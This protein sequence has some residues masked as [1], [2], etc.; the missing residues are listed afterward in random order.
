MASFFDAFGTDIIAGGSTLA[1]V[2]GALKLLY[3]ALKDERQRVASLGDKYA[4]ELER[5]RKSFEDERLEWVKERDYLKA[6]VASLRLQVKELYG[7]LYNL[8]KKI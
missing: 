1:L 7:L 3:A 6:E 2:A 8:D 4:L 5:E